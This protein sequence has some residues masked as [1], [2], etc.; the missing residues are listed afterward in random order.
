MAPKLPLL[1]RMKENPKADWAINDI[2][3][4][5]RSY[6]V[7]ISPP[8]GGGSHYKVYSELLEEILTIPSH[9]PIKPIYIKK[10][11]SFIAMC[12]Q[13]QRENEEERD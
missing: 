2:E 4:L 7:K 9:K 3:T 11:V 13:K 10:L 6:S 1:K 12:E 5:C 8:T